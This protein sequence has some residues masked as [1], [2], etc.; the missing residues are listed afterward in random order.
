M[1]TKNITD[2]LAKIFGN[3]KAAAA[4]AGLAGVGAGA[5]WHGAKSGEADDER[6]AAELEELLA[7]MKMQQGE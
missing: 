4:G 1:K 5:A 3:P 7:L 6:E 2:T